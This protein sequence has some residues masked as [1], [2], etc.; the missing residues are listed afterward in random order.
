MML[1]L[2]ILS[3]PDKKEKEEEEKNIAQPLYNA[4][5]RTYM[6]L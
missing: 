1:V 4:V 3:S 2:F 6:P 5:Q